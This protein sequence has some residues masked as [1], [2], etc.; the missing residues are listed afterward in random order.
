MKISIVCLV[1]NL[2]LAAALVVPLRQGGLGI[3]EHGD[4]DLQRRAAGLRAAE[5]TGE[6]GNGTAA[7]HIS[8]AGRRRR[9]WPDCV[10]WF[11]WQLWENQLGHATIALKIGA[12]FV[13][14]GIAGW[15]Y[16]LTA[17]AFK[18]PAAK[19]MMEFALAKFKTELNR[20]ERRERRL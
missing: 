11:G 13:P 20:S 10:A 15:I 5:K 8:A 18:I 2:I 7:R 19:E 17:L 3:A 12:V 16:W 6:T 4:F 1:V 14:A 9:C